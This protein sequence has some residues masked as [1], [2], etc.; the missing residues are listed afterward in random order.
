M[1][2]P[3]EVEKQIEREKIAAYDVDPSLFPKR[4]G[5]KCFIAFIEDKQLVKK[6]LK[7]TVG[8]WDVKR[9]PTPRANVVHPPL[10]ES[11]L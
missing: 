10:E 4:S 3:L 6:I 7:S 11:A 8:G 5:S 2:V 1:R 9:K